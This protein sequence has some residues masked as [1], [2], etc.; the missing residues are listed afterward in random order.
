MNR[1][2]LAWGLGSVLVGVLLRGKTPFRRSVAEQFIAWGAIDAAL[3]LFGMRQNQHNQERR[4]LGEYTREEHDQ[5]ARR[6]EGILWINA[7]LNVLYLLAGAWLTRRERPAR[8]GMGWGI[9]LQALFLFFFDPINAM[10][11]RQKRHEQA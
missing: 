5:Q 9:I 4:A 2:L 10:I 3:A 1:V 7:G 8:R 6:L 11:L